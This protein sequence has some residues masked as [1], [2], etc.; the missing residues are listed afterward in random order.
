MLLA[1]LIVS[2]C[3]LSLL[4]VAGACLLGA[5]FCWA[6]LY[7]TRNMQLYARLGTILPR[8]RNSWEE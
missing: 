5:I 3:I 1:L 6:S 7:L 2:S 4:L 8:P